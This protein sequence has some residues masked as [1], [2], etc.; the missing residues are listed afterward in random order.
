MAEGKI[1]VGIFGHDAGFGSSLNSATTKTAA[2]QKKMAALSA[3]LQ[4]VGR[5]M[6]MYVTAPIVAGMGLAVKA[7]IDEEKQMTLLSQSMK[8]NAKASDAQVAAAGRWVTKSAEATGIAKSQLI[9]AFS[10]LERATKNT[11]ESEKLMSIA[12][13][14]SAARGKPLEAVVLAISKAYLGQTAGLGRL[15]VA[16]KDYTVNQAKLATA[17]AAVGK[18]Q[19]DYDQVL[20]DG[21]ATAVDRAGALARLGAAHETLKKVLSGTTG[22]LMTFDQIMGK[23]VKTY[24]GAA[25]TA[26]ETTAG[27]MAIL[28]VKVTELGVQL[29]T[30]L[31]PYVDKLVGVLSNLAS[32][33]SGHAAFTAIALGAAAAVGPI[34]MLTGKIL[35]LVNMFINLR[36]AAIAAGMASAA[37]QMATFGLAVGAAAITMAAL[38]VAAW[39]VH[40]A[41]VAFNQDSSAAGSSAS[42]LDKYISGMT[43][44]MAKWVHEMANGDVSLRR[45]QVGI[46]AFIASL[47]VARQ[48]AMSLGDNSMVNRIDAL[49]AK[50]KALA[51]TP[52]APD[53]KPAQLAAAIESTKARV[54]S[55]RD[56]LEVL[57]KMKPTPQVKA[58]TAA[59]HAALDKVTVKLKALQ[60]LKTQVTVTADTAHAQARLQIIMNMVNSLHSKTIAINV[61]Q[62]GIRGVGGLASGGIVTRPTLA[63]IGESGPEAVVPL[64]GGR[65]RGMAGAGG[66]NV[67]INIGNVYA[68][69][70]AEAQASGTGIANAVITKLAQ[71]KRATARGTP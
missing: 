64:S 70:P 51:G 66:G 23:A 50:Y 16:T 15:G 30:V 39:K 33:A 21:N 9:P 5:S 27:K 3:G 52:A 67:T 18:A 47:V 14:I 36:A 63:V 11:A 49:I 34:L 22:V 37:A 62:Q 53:L 12:M 61:L 32:S 54:A 46:Q 48:K 45:G 24:G 55:L 42:Y 1:R 25:A 2:F 43:T 57:G 29:G 65:G 38:A 26:A 58:E 28:K 35:A 69:N 40:A 6:T 19:Q 7:A 41:I 60:S 68:R 59:A 44:S 56:R 10:Q 13:D 20:K 31:I 17:Q 8:L 71:A 4:K